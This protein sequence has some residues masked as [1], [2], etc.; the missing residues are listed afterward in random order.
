MI[1]GAI[2]HIAFALS[3]DRAVDTALG[4][5]GV[6]TLHRHDGK[7]I[8]FVTGFGDFHRRRQPSQPATDHRYSDSTCHRFF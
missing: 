6:R 3:I 8:D 5:D 2:S 7:Q 1:A 4:A